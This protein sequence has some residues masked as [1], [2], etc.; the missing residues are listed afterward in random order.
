MQARRYT[1][2]DGIKFGG[3]FLAYQGDP[4]AVH[5][6]FVVR[7]LRRGR[8]LSDAS[9]SAASRAAVGAKK[10]L[11]LAFVDPEVRDAPVEYITAILTEGPLHEASSGRA[12]VSGPA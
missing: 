7:V 11:L 12:N 8:M 10:R 2:T 4:L 9:L 3:H 1:L 6:A 5:A